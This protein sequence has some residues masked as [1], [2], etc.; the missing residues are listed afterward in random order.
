M[1][2]YIAGRAITGDSM[3]GE[4]ALRIALK[5][6]AQ[7]KKKKP[8]FGAALATN[9]GTLQLLFCFRVSTC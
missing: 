5:Y 1:N 2:Q 4:A 3:G 8:T 6:Y 7:E 9:P